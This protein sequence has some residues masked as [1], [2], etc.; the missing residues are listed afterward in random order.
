MDRIG[1]SSRRTRRLALACAGAALWLATTGCAGLQRLGDPVDGFG[2]WR[3][4]ATQQA[5]FDRLS[6]VL[7]TKARRL[8]AETR[9]VVLRAVFQAAESHALDPQL[10]LAVMHVESGF[11]PRARGPAGAL[12]LM[13]VMPSSG[14]LMARELDIPWHGPATLYEPK[15]NVQIGAAYLARMHKQFEDMELSLAAYNMGPGA[16]QAMLR[17]G[18]WPQGNYSGKVKRRLAAI[19][20]AVVVAMARSSAGAD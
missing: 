10:L 20:E 4:T 16:L 8:D 18:G 13:Q 11:N 1:A 12:G 14:R 2:S 9:A 15:I 6:Q 5:S 3:P 19:R 17:R 7:E